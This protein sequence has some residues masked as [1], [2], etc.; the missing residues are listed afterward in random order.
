MTALLF[1]CGGDK[2]ERDAC[3]YEP[4]TDSSDCAEGL[5]CQRPGA[6]TQSCAGVCVKSCETDVDCGEGRTCA[7]LT[8]IESGRQKFCR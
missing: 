6:C 7:G 3:T 8:T 1:G 2:Q 5:F 4:A